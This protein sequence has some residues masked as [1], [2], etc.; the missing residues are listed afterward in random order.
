VLTPWIAL[1]CLA[2]KTLCIQGGVEMGQFC[3]TLVGKLLEEILV[4]Y[5]PRGSY[6]WLARVILYR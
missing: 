6:C 5:D 3:G 2:T 1:L 4:E